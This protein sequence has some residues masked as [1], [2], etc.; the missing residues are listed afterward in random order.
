[1][2][3]FRSSQ[4][5]NFNAWLQPYIRVD[6]LGCCWFTIQI[7][8]LSL[9]SLLW[10]SPCKMPNPELDRKMVVAKWTLVF[11]DFPLFFSSD[12]GVKKTK[13]MPPKVA[14]GLVW[15]NSFFLDQTCNLSYFSH[16][17]S[18]RETNFTPKSALCSAIPNLQQSNLSEKIQQ[19][20]IKIFKIPLKDTNYSH[21]IP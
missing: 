7:Q 14:V 11:K 19:N 13:R 6:N 4:N 5:W 9:E 17:P 15:T 3:F 8:K 21:K 16:K 10:N 12:F 18:L 1:M 20:I 2:A